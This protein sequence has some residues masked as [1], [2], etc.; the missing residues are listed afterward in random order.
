MLIE[1]KKMESEQFVLTCTRDDGS[2]TWAKL[3]PRMEYHDLAHFVVEKELQL[4]NAF[5]G[6]VEQGHDIQ[7]FEIARDQRPDELIP[8]NLSKESIQTEHIVNLLMS[9]TLNYGQDENFLERLRTILEDNNISFPVVLTDESLERIRK[10]YK[11][12]VEQVS[13]LSIDEKITLSW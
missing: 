2:V 6:M 8:A 13:Q 12:L 7:D 9:E 5:Y 10:H 3:K 4:R 11:T 1:F